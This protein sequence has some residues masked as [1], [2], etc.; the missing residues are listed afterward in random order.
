MRR[1]E[2]ENYAVQALGASTGERELGYVSFGSPLAF[3]SELLNMMEERGL[4]GTDGEGWCMS[5]LAFYF[6]MQ[7][8]AEEGGKK[9]FTEERLR[10]SG[11][12]DCLGERARISAQIY[13]GIVVVGQRV[14]P[15]KLKTFPRRRV[16]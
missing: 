3:L 4:T 5:E 12:K 11:P 15:R 2:E 13:Q 6:T 9:A 14:S 7:N 10:L 1:R 8:K 16:A